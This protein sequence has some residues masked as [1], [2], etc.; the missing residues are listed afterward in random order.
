[1]SGEAC[2]QKINDD[3]DKYHQTH[4]EWDDRLLKAIGFRSIEE[5]KMS[6]IK[7]IAISDKDRLIKE[8]QKAL[9]GY[10]KDP[11]SDNAAKLKD[12]GVKPQTVKDERKKKEM[13]SKERNIS[14]L[15]KRE[16][17]Q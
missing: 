17:Q 15:S 13:T 16:K 1:M 7:S 14:N 11:S 4:D 10:I 9:D 12:V 5:S 2:K 8:K 3:S 6:D